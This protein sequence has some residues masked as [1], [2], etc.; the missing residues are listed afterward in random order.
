MMS[1]YEKFFLA[2]VQLIYAEQ[3]SLYNFIILR[4]KRLQHRCFPVELL[5]LSR[6]V[7][8]ASENNVLLHNKKL[9]RA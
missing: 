9:Q 1:V 2:E 5:K 4:K 6:A 7:V 3:I 8:V